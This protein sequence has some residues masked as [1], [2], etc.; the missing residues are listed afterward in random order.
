MC[1]ACAAGKFSAQT[2]LS[3]DAQCQAC[4]AGETTPAAGATAA[5]QCFTIPCDDANLPPA[6]GSPG[7]CPATL[8][9]GA[10]CGPACDAG[11]EASSGSNPRSC[12]V[13][14]L[15]DNV[16]CTACPAGKYESQ[17]TAPMPSCAF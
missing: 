6:N 8:L 10:T 4:A 2:G 12:F 16:A 1:E 14:V 11:F 3:S 17:N 13:G 7:T 15:T 9:S 5:S